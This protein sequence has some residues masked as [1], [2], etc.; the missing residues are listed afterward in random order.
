M[1]RVHS[2]TLLG[3]LGIATSTGRLLALQPCPSP[4]PKGF[5]AP[6]ILLNAL[7]VVLS[8]I[9]ISS[10]IT[11]PL[12][13]PDRV[14]LHTKTIATVSPLAGIPGLLL[15]VQVSFILNISKENKTSASN[16]LKLLKLLCR[17]HGTRTRKTFLRG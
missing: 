10:T 8:S 11:S 4:K 7:R 3:A 6:C 17:R 14:S 13:H 12:E 15:F 1:R 2:L 9:W 5:S 16:S